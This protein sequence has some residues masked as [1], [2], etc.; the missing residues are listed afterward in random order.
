MAQVGAEAHLVTLVMW[1]GSME[2][3]LTIRVQAHPASAVAMET[4]V[5]LVS[6]AASIHWSLALSSLNYYGGETAGALWMLRLAE[7]AGVGEAEDRRRE[8]RRWTCY[9]ADFLVL[10]LEALGRHQS[11]GVVEVAAIRIPEVDGIAVKGR[12]G[13]FVDR[14]MESGMTGRLGLQKAI[15]DGWIKYDKP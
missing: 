6:Q 14:K 8:W 5:C 10:G 15:S 3:S 12:A 11:V 1:D 13:A 7:T 2:K 4:C 9:L